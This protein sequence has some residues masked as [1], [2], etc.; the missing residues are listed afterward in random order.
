[1]LRLAVADDDQL[2]ATVADLGKRVTQLRDL[3]AAE[4]SAKVADEGEHHGLPAPQL[5]EA[6][7]PPVRIEHAD[8][9]EPPGDI[10]C[11]GSSYL[12]LIVVWTAMRVNSASVT[13]KL[14]ST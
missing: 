3:L 10:H 9:L 8:V 14:L 1:M 11:L 12:D 13:S 7:V 2:G 6:N 5:T 4:D